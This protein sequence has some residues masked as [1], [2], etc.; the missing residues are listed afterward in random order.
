[1]ELTR[2]GAEGVSK[3]GFSL[4]K[5]HTVFEGCRPCRS[6]VLQE[7]KVQGIGSTV[8]RR[9]QTCPHRVTLIHATPGISGTVSGAGGRDADHIRCAAWWLTLS[10]SLP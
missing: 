3:G 10:D 8:A 9:C 7:R 1:M 4:V 5:C 2:Q 6:R